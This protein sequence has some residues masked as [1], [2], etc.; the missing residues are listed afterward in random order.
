MHD[1]VLA[2]LRRV[3]R[4]VRVLG[5]QKSRPFANVQF[6]RLTIVYTFIIYRRIAKFEVAS[7][8]SKIS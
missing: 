8:F 3:R 6:L 1:N 4:T 2:H 5:D 7:I